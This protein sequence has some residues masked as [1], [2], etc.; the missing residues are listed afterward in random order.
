MAIWPDNRTMGYTAQQHGP[1]TRRS[2]LE[3]V[4]H[5]AVGAYSLGGWPAL[6]GSCE[7]GVRPCGDDEQ[8]TAQSTFQRHVYRHT[9]DSPRATLS[10]VLCGDAECWRSQAAAPQHPRCPCSCTL[11]RCVWSVRLPR[12]RL[13]LAGAWIRAWDLATVNATARR[14]W[15]CSWLYMTLSLPCCCRASAH[16]IPSC[17][18]ATA[19]GMP[20]TRP[21]AGLPLLQCGQQLN[22]ATA[23]CW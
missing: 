1:A 17:Q 11:P 12:C 21:S 19:A 16:H 22:P 23:C 8:P 2:P 6:A 18:C 9:L 5:F 15:C 13:G 14:T 4:V 7:E 3:A 20:S 10:G